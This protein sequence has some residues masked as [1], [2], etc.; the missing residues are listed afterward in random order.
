M[1]RLALVTAVAAVVFT[2]ESR[3]QSSDSALTLGKVDV[4]QH[5]EGQLTP[6]R[7]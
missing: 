1:K 7:C 6:T 4:H 2:P 5:T 3:A